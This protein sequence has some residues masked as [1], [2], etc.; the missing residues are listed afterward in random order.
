[1]MAFVEVE[2]T[3]NGLTQGQLL[4]LANH[5][6]REC[7]GSGYGLND[8]VCACVYRRIFDACYDC[9]QAITPHT[10][11]VQ[12]DSIYKS[13]PEEEFRADFWAVAHRALIGRPALAETFDVY[14]AEERGAR[15]AAAILGISTGVLFR[16]A[17]DIK[18]LVGRA[19]R[20]VQPYPLFPSRQYFV[21]SGL[22]TMPQPLKEPAK[23]CPIPFVYEFE[24]AA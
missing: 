24:A 5:D 14:F 15:I 3:L 10:S 8:P 2:S 11:R 23:V 13:R 22:V 1:M 17:T 18:R 16:R 12:S 6:C 9:Y 7:A 21:R 20:D 4:I 19:F